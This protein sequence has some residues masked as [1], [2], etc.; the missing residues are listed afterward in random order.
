MIIVGEKRLCG[1][2]FRFHFSGVEYERFV[3]DYRSFMGELPPFKKLGFDNLEGLL[4]S[5]PDVVTVV[6][7]YD[8]CILKA[9]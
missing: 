2:V 9:S 6:S 4:K 7:T 1:N 8:S 3:S 5:I